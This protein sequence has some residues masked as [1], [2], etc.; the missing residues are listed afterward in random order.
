MSSNSRYHIEVWKV[1]FWVFIGV[2]LMC[3]L[4]AIRSTCIDIANSRDDCVIILSSNRSNP[5][6]DRPPSNDQK[7][8]IQPIMQDGK[9]I[10]NV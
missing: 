9:A 8:I 5:S 10:H 4:S 7:N 2:F 6:K 1:G 3:V